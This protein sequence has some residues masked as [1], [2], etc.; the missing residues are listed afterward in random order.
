MSEAIRSVSQGDP[1]TVDHLLAFH[2]RLL[3]DTRLAAHA[4]VIRTQQNWIGGSA[5]NPCSASFVPPPHE[6]VPGLL[7]DLRAFLYAARTNDAQSSFLVGGTRSRRSAA[8]PG[9][10]RSARSGADLYCR[11]RTRPNDL[12]RTACSAVGAHANLRSSTHS[13]WAGR[14]RLCP[15]RPS[16]RGSAVT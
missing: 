11:E 4:G 14:M 2:Q 6:L 7:E 8:R 15:T 5:Y 1:I 10:R 12:R 9:T 3:A 16:L 13:E